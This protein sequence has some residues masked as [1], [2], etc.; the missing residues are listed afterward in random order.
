[1]S[2]V[3]TGFDFCS[4]ITAYYIVMIDLHTHSLLSDGVLLPTELVQ[5]ANHAGYR[6]LAITDHVD[7][8]N[9]D[10]A[11]PR[12][13]EA[14]NELKDHTPV[15]AIPGAEVTHVPPALVG[16]LVQK[17]REL[18]AM[19]VIVHG[20]TVAEPVIAGT[21]RAAIESGADILSH[22]GLIRMEDAV[23]AR[24]KGVALEITARKGHSLSNGHVAKVAMAA[25]ATMVINTDAHA[26]EDLIS[27]ERAAIILRSAGIPEE[28][29]ETIFANSQK[30]V[31]NIGR[32]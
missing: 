3:W 28:N 20:E 18:G 7:R 14:L 27:R 21:N 12:L 22:P 23:L 17:A 5:R 11:V 15:Q 4:M 19:I 26:P 31:D 32:G 16:A 6:A 13:V 2:K 9:I 10:F 25:G 29:I 30:L 1:M 8:S 24:E